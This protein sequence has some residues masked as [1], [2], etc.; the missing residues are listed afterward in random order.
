MRRPDCRSVEDTTALMTTGGTGVASRQGHDQHDEEHGRQLQMSEPACILRWVFHRGPDTLTCA[1]EAA[2]RSSYDVCVFLTGTSLR[3]RSNTSTR[4]RA[5][6]AATQRLHRCFV[7]V[8]GSRN[9]A[10][11]I[12]GHRGL[13]A[14]M[15]AGPRMTLS[16]I[17]DRLTRSGTPRLVTAME[18]IYRYEPHTDSGLGT[19]AHGDFASRVSDGRDVQE[20]GTKSVHHVIIVVITHLEDPA[21]EH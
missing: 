2:R 7:R 6:F 4:P 21:R 8:D 10:R 13:I 1:V 12:E 15:G 9:T 20:L 3:E 19:S 5:P 14:R 18:S 16:I 17:C 11:A